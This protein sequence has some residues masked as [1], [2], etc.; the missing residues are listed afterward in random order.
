MPE[1]LAALFRDGGIKNLADAHGHAC[2][3]NRAPLIHEILQ[4]DGSAFVVVGTFE[5]VE[6]N[7]S[8][9]FGQKRYLIV[10]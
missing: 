10:H 9:P 3:W 7:N 2:S 1:G 4:H 8:R 6:V 5:S